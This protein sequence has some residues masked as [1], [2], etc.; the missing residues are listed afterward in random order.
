MAHPR[1]KVKLRAHPSRDASDGEQDPAVAEEHEQQRQKQA[2]DKQTADVGARRRGAL[3]PL[4]GAG[5]SGTF[6]A[7]TA[8]EGSVKKNGWVYY[9]RMSLL[10]S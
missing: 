6:W 2:E 4:D 5:G 8:P 10:M 3:V 7:V 1:S 9:L